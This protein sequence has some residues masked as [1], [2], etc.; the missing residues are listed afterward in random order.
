MALAPIA[1]WIVP[2]DYIGAASRGAQLGLSARAQDEEENRAADRL[3]LAYKTLESQERRASEASQAR[4]EQAA[5]ALAL[6]GKQMDALGKYRQERLS[7]QE[8]ALDLRKKSIEDSLDLRKKAMEQSLDLKN[9][10]LAGKLTDEEKSS[11]NAAQNTKRQAQ[12]K[13][14]DP[15]MTPSAREGLSNTIAQA[16]MI[17][18]AI[19]GRTNRPPVAMPSTNAPPASAALQS[20]PG[21]MSRLWTA[22][23]PGDATNALPAAGMPPSTG[24]AASAPPQIT[25]QEQFDALPSGSVYF[26]EDG[27]R[28]RKP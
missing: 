14:A 15:N 22:I 9:Q 27:K 24:T 13:L 16:D 21:V 20:R 17:I 18:G 26:G 5:A 6:R 19:S 2:P 28:Y 10:A 1:P 8:R 4:H 12:I 3:A 23:F 25:T 11:L 7:E